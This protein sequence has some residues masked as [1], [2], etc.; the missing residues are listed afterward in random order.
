MTISKRALIVGSNSYNHFFFQA[1]DGIRDTSV[2]G[3]QTCALPISAKAERTLRE[4]RDHFDH[5]EGPDVAEKTL[6]FLTDDNSRAYAGE[7]YEKILIRAFLA[8]SEERRVGKKCKFGWW[9]CD[10]GKDIIRD[11]IE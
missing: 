2:T 8:R 10:Q 3:V 4:V 6:S 5:L 9:W 7:D 1:E 11:L